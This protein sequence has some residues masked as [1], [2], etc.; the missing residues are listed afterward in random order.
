MVPVVKTIAGSLDIQYGGQTLS[1]AREATADRVQAFPAG[2]RSQ[3][4]GLGW[5]LRN[6]SDGLC[7]YGIIE[8]DGTDVVQAR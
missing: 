7:C 8:A 6:E 5:L 1:V 2:S 4:G 3:V